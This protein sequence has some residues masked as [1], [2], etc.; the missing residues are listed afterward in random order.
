MAIIKMIDEDEEKE[1]LLKESINLLI[2]DSINYTNDLKDVIESAPLILDGFAN[3]RDILRSVKRGNTFEAAV[4]DKADVCCPPL[5]TTEV[6][7]E[8]TSCE[9]C[10][11]DF[12]HHY[13]EKIAKK[14][15]SAVNN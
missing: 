8:T 6:D 1:A 3:F 13:T 4:R 15:K 7:C 9:D 11:K 14:N 5:F 12:C 2:K 10:W